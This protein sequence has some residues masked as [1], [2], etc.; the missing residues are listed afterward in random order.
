MRSGWAMPRASIVRS[1][2]DPVRTADRDRDGGLEGRSIFTVMAES[3]ALT[4]RVS[5][6]A[7]SNPALL[8]PA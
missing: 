2:H 6:S 7:V 5:S 1:A 4:R 8:N 3:A